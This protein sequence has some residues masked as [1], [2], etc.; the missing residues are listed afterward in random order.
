M[1][2]SFLKK[3][4]S[5]D[6]SSSLFESESDNINNDLT[7]FDNSGMYFFKTTINNMDQMI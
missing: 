2:N 5:K 7:P 3:D 4:F 1:A 6:L